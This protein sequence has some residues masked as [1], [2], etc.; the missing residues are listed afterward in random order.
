MANV[1]G[2]R[3]VASLHYAI[4][5]PNTGE[6][7]YPSSNGN[8]RFNKDRI[9]E[10][11]ANNE[12]YFGEDGKGRP[13]LKRFLSEVKDGVTYP[14]IWDFVPLNTEGSAEMQT[15]LGNM[16]AFE[17][18][19]PTGLIME[20]VK[21]GCSKDGL[22]LDFFAGSGTTGHAVAELN[23]KDGGDRKFIL[24]QLPEP[25]NRDEYKVISDI[26]KERMRRA[27]AK[28]NGKNRAQLSLESLSP[29]VAGFRV[30]KLDTSN[31]KPWNGTQ[32]E[33][34]AGLAQQLELHVD[35]VLTGR[36][37]EDILTEL[38]LKSG[39]PL[40]TKV[41]TTQL[42]GKQVFSVEDGAMLVCLDDKL[43]SEVIKAMAD[44][45]PSR[46]ICLD[47]GFQGNDQLKTNAVQTMKARGVLSFRTV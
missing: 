35:H 31:F 23:A 21:L 7:H 33:E 3:Y 29:Q 30:L 34:A 17:N 43:T 32:Q 47:A 38:L 37:Q 42:A 25:T 11:M 13:K 41:E 28:L 27:L 14:T 20:L 15:L 40:S 45:K 9:A 5:N 26:T 1:K 19:K 39:F 10:L 6:D 16:T 2:G 4:R 36:S 22:V 18:P 8:W 24:V 12:I 46:V 44:K